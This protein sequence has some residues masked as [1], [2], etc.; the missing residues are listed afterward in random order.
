LF[1]NANLLKDDLSARLDNTNPGKGMIH[2]PDWLPIWFYKEL[3]VERRTEKGWINSSGGRNEAWDLLY[4]LLGAC[5]SPLLQVEKI[6]WDNPPSWA[7]S[8]DKNPL[9]ISAAEDILDDVPVTYDFARLG[10]ALA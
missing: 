7:A 6:D 4:Y 9:V 10:E 1:F 5:V 8:W 2:F 3:C